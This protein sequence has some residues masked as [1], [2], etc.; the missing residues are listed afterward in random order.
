MTIGITGASG[1][2]GSHLVKALDGSG[3]KYIDIA[4][5]DILKPE[6]YRGL[7]SVVFCAGLSDPKSDPDALI[8]ANADLPVK[9]A[10]LA[11]SQNV[12][13][14]IFLSSIYALLGA[15]QPFLEDTAPRPIDPYGQS[16]AN[17]EL[18]L[19]H[20]SDIKRSIVRPPLVYGKGAGGN[21]AKL[22]KLSDL[23]IPLP[24]GA[25]DNKRSA[26]SIDNLV[27]AL[28]FLTQQDQLD[29]D[30]QVYHVADQ[31]SYSTQQLMTK[32][33]HIAGKHPYFLSI[34]PSLLMFGLRCLGLKKM[35]DQLCGD[36]T[37]EAHKLNAMGWHPSEHSR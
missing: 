6:T 35:A 7:T 29:F 21:I 9:S 15:E 16:K 10:K 20:L 2:I 25:I 17:A 31:Q 23:Q 26:V 13:H 4:R 11:A 19:S 34:P 22:L 18:G 14:F 1:F 32:I 30:Y 36:L 37:L 5:A 28:L 8:K 3:H 24:F 12:G 33:A 27:S